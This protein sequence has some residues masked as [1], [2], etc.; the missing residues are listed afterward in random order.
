MAIDLVIFGSAALG[1]ERPRDI[2]VAYSGDWTPEDE[3][4][5][6]RWAKEAGLPPDLPI[7][8]HHVPDHCPIYL[9]TPEGARHAHVPLRGKR[10][11][12]WIAYTDLPAR[13]RA[14]GADASA[15]ASAIDGARLGVEETP[16]P[17]RDWETYTQG[18]TALRRAIAHAP[19][20]A[21]AGPIARGLDRL[22]EYGLTEEQRARLLPGNQAG[23]GEHLVPYVREDGLHSCYGGAVVRW[24][25]IG[26]CS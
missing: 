25:E 2:D 26:Q 17:L 23:A 1:A 18:L 11:V 19:A 24:E 7:D 16:F 4:E 8:A 20:W 13:V 15:L 21:G 14:H 12:G 6:R 5:V 10:T 3:T 9:P 22:L